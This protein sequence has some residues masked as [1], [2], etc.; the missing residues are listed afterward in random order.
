[1]ASFATSAH[2]A[3]LAV[4]VGVEPGGSAVEVGGLL[5]VTVT[6]AGCGW[7]VAPFVTVAD[8]VAGTFVE[9]AATGPQSATTP[10]ATTRWSARMVPPV[11][12]PLLG[13]DAGS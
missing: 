2:P 6:V 13:H 4:V 12:R 3:G 1:M 9:Q 8:D 11:A 10:A 5:A 7:L